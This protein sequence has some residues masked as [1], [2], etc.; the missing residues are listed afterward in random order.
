MKATLLV[1]DIDGTLIPYQ[2]H[3]IAPNTKQALIALQEKGVIIAIASGRVSQGIASFADELRLAEF[4]GY[5]IANNGAQIVDWKTKE[6]L[7][8]KE[9][10]SAMVQELC[11]KRKELG[12]NVMLMQKDVV[13][14]SGYDAAVQVDHVAIDIDFVWPHDI[15]RYAQKQTFRMNLTSDVPGR[16]DQV[17]DYLKKKYADKISLARPQSIFLDVMS[18]G[19]NKSVAMQFL[20]NHLNMGIDQVVAVGD[21]GNDL[22][23]IRDAGI[24]VAM[25]NASAD[26]K[27]IAKVIAP[28]VNDEGLVWVAKKY[29]D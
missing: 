10:P 27:A 14:M 23:M 26:V 21:G 29:F 16:Q 4:G 12:V 20:A 17:F 9:L 19:V 13:V 15:M 6:V 22:E 28:D 24:G 7:F 18:P 1:T 3:E 5:V 11:A 25:G 8:A 2:T